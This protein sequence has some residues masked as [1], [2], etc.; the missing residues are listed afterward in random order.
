MI[1]QRR[2]WNTFKPY[3]QRKFLRITL[4]TFLLQGNI[5]GKFI[6]SSVKRIRLRDNS[7]WGVKWKYKFK[8][9]TVQPFCKEEFVHV[10]FDGF[11][12]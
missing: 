8:E 6:K 5:M 2:K 3:S 4:Y 7:V 11:A 1:A 9:I 12:N 10:F